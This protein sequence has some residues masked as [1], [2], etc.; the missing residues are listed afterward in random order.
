MR[1]CPIRTPFPVGEGT[2]SDYATFDVGYSL[3][4]GPNSKIGGFVGY[5]YY[6]ENKSAYGCTQIANSNSDCVPSIPNSTLGIT[7]NDRW[8]SFRI[9]LNGVVTLV[10][11]LTLTADA[12]YLPYVAFRGT[13]NHVLRTDVPNTISPETGAGQGVQL[14]AIMAY[15]VDEFP[16]RRCGRPL[17]GDVGDR[18]L[19]QLIW[20]GVPLSNIAGPNRT[21]RR[22]PAGL[23]QAERNQIAVWPR[24]HLHARCRSTLGMK[25]GTAV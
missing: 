14:E 24:G 16:Q 5:N 8:D 7:E 23:V 4:R 11:R 13:D 3:F 22:V 2:V 20:Y 25:H 19:Y 6:T 18:W 21:L 15:A 12:A 17:L 9:G 1:P 10:D